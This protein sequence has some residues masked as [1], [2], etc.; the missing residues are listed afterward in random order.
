MNNFPAPA[1]PAPTLTDANP[2]RLQAERTRLFSEMADQQ[3]LALQ[4]FRRLLSIERNPPI[5]EVID[6]G[7]IPRLVHFLSFD[8]LPVSMI[9]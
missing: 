9:V 1:D 7:I 5:Q 8:H 2:H 4:F 3:L 6:T